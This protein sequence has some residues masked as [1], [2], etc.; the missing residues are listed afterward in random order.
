MT[1]TAV[2]EPPAGAHIWLQRVLGGKA[3]RF[4]CHQGHKHKT[5][6]SAL[7]CQAKAQRR[8]DREFKARCQPALAEARA[9]FRRLPDEERGLPW[10]DIVLPRR[11][12][13]CGVGLV[14]ALVAIGGLLG[15][16]LCLLYRLLGA[17]IA[18]E[19]LGSLA[20]LVLGLVPV[21]CWLGTRREIAA[22]DKRDLPA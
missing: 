2:P 22:P 20:V 19:V 21:L 5:A 15:S 12:A 1:T 17:V 16:A 8:I 6:E 14:T 11:W 13:I 3:W 9:R 4:C 10:D 7:R 18:D